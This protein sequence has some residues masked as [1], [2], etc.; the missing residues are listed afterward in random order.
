MRLYN[1]TNTGEPEM[2]YLLLNNVD[3]R[4]VTQDHKE[5]LDDSITLEEIKEAI[6]GLKG[7]TSPRAD[8]LT[9]EFYLKIANTFIRSFI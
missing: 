2:V 9:L 3:I 1:Q 8:G 7:N 4:K 6:A 5:E